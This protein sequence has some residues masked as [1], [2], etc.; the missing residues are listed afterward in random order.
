MTSQ[1][2]QINKMVTKQLF[3]VEIALDAGTV[4]FSTKTYNY[5]YTSGSQLYQP[6]IKNL[7]Y[8]ISAGVCTIPTLNASLR[9]NFLNKA[10][11]DSG[12]S[13]LEYLDNNYVEKCEIKVYEIRP[14]TWN[15]VFA[16]DCKILRFHGMVNNLSDVTENTFSMLCSN[17]IY[18]LKDNLPLQVLTECDYPNID[19]DDLGETANIIYGDLDKVYCHAID[20]GQASPLSTDLTDSATT[21]VLSD[22]SKFPDTGT[23]GIEE[24]LISYTGRTDNSFTGCT[25]GYNSTTAIEH[26]K[27][28][29]CWEHKSSFDYLLASHEVKSIGDIYV[30]DI[31][32]TSS[33]TKFTG[34]AGNTCPGYGNIAIIRANSKQVF[35]QR[36]NIETDD[37]IAVNDGI[38][39]D[40]N[41]SMQQHSI[42]MHATL[43]GDSASESSWIDGNTSTG[44]YAKAASKYVYYS[45][46]TE[47]SKTYVWI[48]CKQNVSPSTLYVALAAGSTQSFSTLP[49]GGGWIRAT[50]T[51]T[52]YDGSNVQIYASADD[53]ITVYEVYKEV[54]YVEVETHTKTGDAY[55]T[56]TATKTGTVTLTGNSSANL[57]IGSDFRANVEG[58][59]D[60]GAGTI[61]GSAYDL[62]E[63]PDN[64]I[65][66]IWTELLGRSSGEIGSSFDTT[67]STYGATTGW[68]IVSD[69]P[70][71]KTTNAAAGTQEAAV[72]FGY[73]DVT[74]LYN[75][76]SWTSGNNMIAGAYSLGG[77]GTQSAAL[78][79]GGLFNDG[80]GSDP[81]KASEE[82]N[83]SVWSA[84]G[85]LSETKDRVGGGVG[86]QS[87]AMCL[88]GWTWEKISECE[89]YNGTAWS[90]SGNMSEDKRSLAGAGTLSAGL[91]CGG[92]NDSWTRVTTTEEFD[93]SSWS[94]GGNML[95]GRERLASCGTQSAALNF[96]GYDGFTSYKDTESYDGTSW[97]TKADLNVSNSSMGGCGSNTAALCAGNGGG[98]LTLVEKYFGGESID[99]RFA[100]VMQNIG[101]TL[102]EIFD[103]LALQGK[104]RI[105]FDN[106]Y[107][108]MV[109]Q[110]STP[111]SANDTIVFTKADRFQGTVFK[112]TDALKISNKIIGLYNT[113]QNSI[114]VSGTDSIARYGT[115]ETSIKLNAIK[116]L[117]QATEV[118]NWIL[119]NEETPIWEV[120]LPTPT[121][122]LLLSF[123]DYF[124][125][126][127]TNVKDNTNFRIMY[128]GYDGHRV[129]LKGLQ[130]V[131]S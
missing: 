65:E 7:N 1:A 24:E 99:W 14:H 19:P 102:P 98:G 91:A 90:A 131:E 128:K 41:I 61:T 89:Q 105:F 43:Y 78:A 54:E 23:L 55:K 116:G 67:G 42:P 30:D 8:N 79:F 117:D 63:R 107:L 74:Y 130:W 10:F 85:D 6:F 76:T 32:I 114:T 59:R 46:T 115:M 69:L 48:H 72:V 44:A 68:T 70:G 52:N 73:T 29:W 77:C 66:H 28:M 124:S 126:T 103:L 97:T 25:R 16:T 17:L 57:Q 4:Y 2:N 93:G 40:D 62:I 51:V 87:A 5:D 9:I 3:L 31:L 95:V 119:D 106:Q 110:T 34:Q 37:Q 100:F 104:A 129:L 38:D 58:Y 94:A 15:E 96:A 120:I 12:N 26:D 81:Q 50:I 111:P 80:E 121:P 13:L 22:G 86:T 33:C 127:E 21:V 83:G 75:G 20:A 47:C 11:D 101:T 71:A 18:G 88:G 36:V 112:K 53:K 27:G 108:E 122:A 84:G 92:V 39:V 35:Q 45:G 60:D 82:F 118:V 113:E 56:G 123:E 125:F 64:V 49:P 109:Y